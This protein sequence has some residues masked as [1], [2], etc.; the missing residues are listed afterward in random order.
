LR[1]IPLNITTATT[2]DILSIP[3]N[4]KSRYL[5]FEEYTGSVH[6][7]DG[8]LAQYGL[9]IPMGYV[10]WFMGTTPSWVMMV[11]IS[12]ASRQIMSRRMGNRPGPGAYQAERPR[13]PSGAMPPPAARGGSSKGKMVN[14]KK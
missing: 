1:I 14:K 12:F 5:D 7:P 2:S 4:A 3:S 13:A 11:I 6:P 8:W 9:L 10:L